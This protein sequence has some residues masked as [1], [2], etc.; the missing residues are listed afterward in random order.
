[1]TTDPQT[2][3]YAYLACRT[4]GHAWKFSLSINGSISVELVC[5]RCKAERKDTVGG[6]GEVLA[7]QYAYPKDYLGTGRVP[8][9][10][11]RSTLVGRERLKGKK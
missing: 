9:N 6:G 5:T 10:D 8:R 4:F 1:M 11:Y 3:P 2:L 7:R